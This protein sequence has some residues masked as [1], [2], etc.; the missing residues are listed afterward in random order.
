MGEIHPNGCNLNIS[1]S[2][3]SR[4]ALSVP[5]FSSAPRFCICG[6]G[7]EGKMGGFAVGGCSPASVAWPR[8]GTGGCTET[9]SL[10][11][12]PPGLCLPQRC[13]LLMA[14]GS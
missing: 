10:E 6:G 8:A 2:P 13:Y 11:R 3:W 1:S 12:S 14:G 7:W 4:L 5:G 9:P